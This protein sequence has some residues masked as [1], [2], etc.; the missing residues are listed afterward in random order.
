[1]GRWMIQLFSLKQLDAMEQ[2]DYD[3]LKNIILKQLETN[4]EILK[5]LDKKVRPIY[6]QIAAKKKTRPI[7][8][9]PA[10][11]KKTRPGYKR[12]ASKRHR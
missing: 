7:G 2:K 3:I 8:K 10:A 12:R 11:K 5:V 4:S 1:M 9:Q 6:K